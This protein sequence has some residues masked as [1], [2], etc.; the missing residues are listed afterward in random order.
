MP[1]TPKAECHVCHKV[2]KNADCRNVH[3]LNAHGITG[4]MMKANYGSLVISP[5]IPRLTASTVP[6][7]SVST[8]PNMSVSTIPMSNS[9]AM[10]A[11]PISDSEE[12]Y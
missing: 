11:I 7:M 5:V 8:L 10:A 4:E 1:G 9:E 2:F 12:D 3:R 6:S